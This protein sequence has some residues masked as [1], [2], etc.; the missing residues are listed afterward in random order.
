MSGLGFPSIIHDSVILELTST[1]IESVGFW[2]MIGG[3]RIIYVVRH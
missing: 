2:I 1:I 3:A